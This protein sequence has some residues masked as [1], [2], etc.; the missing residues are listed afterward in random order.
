MAETAFRFNSPADGLSL[1][2]WKWTPAARPRAIVQISH[3]LA[4]HAL[5]YRRLAA[6]LN[7]AGIA[8]YANDHR[9]HG[10]T[11]PEGGAQ[12]DFGAAG[13]AGLVGDVKALTD[14]IRSENDSA[15]VILLGHSMGSFAAQTYLLDHSSAIDACVLSGSSDI[16]TI[17]QMAMSG[18]DMSLG[19]FNAAFEPARTPF[20]WLSRDEAEVDKYVADPMCGFDAPPETSMSMMGG[21]ARIGEAGEIGK[22]CKDLPVYIFSG[23]KDPV[24][25]MGMLVNMLAERLKTAGLTDLA[26]KLYADG[27]H[28]MFNEI[29]RDEVTR[30]LVAWIETKAL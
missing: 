28:E 10:A 6:A 2:A 30:D 15:P 16:P 20:D 18:A 24:G 23:D 7:E 5:R 11:I 29:N 19:A 8:V 12:G 21:A 17:A 27:R 4:E 14:I 25:G 22:I 26:V 1:A 9:G 3:G 13:W